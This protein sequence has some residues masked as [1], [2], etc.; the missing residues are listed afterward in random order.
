MS[1]GEDMKEEKKKREGKGRRKKGRR[2][3]G[4][5]GYQVFTPVPDI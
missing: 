4:K 3:G 5:V 2:E 1:F